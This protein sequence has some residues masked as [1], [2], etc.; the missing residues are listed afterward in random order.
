[1]SGRQE[2][3]T[4]NGGTNDQDFTVGTSD[5]N[6]MVNE[7]TV[8]VKTLER[9][10]NEWIDREMSDTV[11]TVK[12][13]MQNA[14]FTAVD[15]IVA[16]KIEVTIRSINASSDRDATSVRGKSEGGEHIEI[17]AP[18]NTHLKTIMY[19]IYQIWMMT[20]ETI[21]RTK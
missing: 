5:K 3:A 15:S 14:S 11:D 20:L 9:S 6:L 7:N 8:I 19:Y 4:I 13:R 12:E 2:N 17:T 16:P 21:F 10:L 1:M 18:L